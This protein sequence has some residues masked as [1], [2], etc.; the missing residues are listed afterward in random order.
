[1]DIQ[2]FVSREKLRADSFRLLAACF[3]EPQRDMFE[4]GLLHNLAGSLKMICPG[5]VDYAEEMIKLLPLHSD[6]ELLVDYSRLFVGPTGLLAAPYG[7]V[8]LDKD[9]CVMGD[10]T[11]AVIAFYNS[12][13]LVMDGDFKEMPDHI[14]VELE[15]MYYLAYKE[16][17][18]LELPD[19]TAAAAALESQEFF[20]NKFLRPWAD[21]FAGKMMEGAETAFYRA[22]AGCLSALL[23]RSDIR[24]S[25]PEELKA[26]AAI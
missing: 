8:Y 4:E 14:A 13:G 24:S 17:E 7:S 22:L 20:I 18:A 25:L 23:Y 19:M 21:K 3:Y 6:E 11:M 12:H 15:F 1:M 9:R 10:S 26:T 16:I 5:A 2:T